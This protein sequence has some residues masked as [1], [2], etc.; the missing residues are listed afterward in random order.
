MSDE[1]WICLSPACDLVP[2]QMPSWQV[3]R[4]GRRLPFLGVRLYKQNARNV[5][6]DI[7]TNRYL[8]LRLGDAITCFSLNEPSN[9]QAAPR[10]Q[11]LFAENQGRFT[12]RNF[13]FK[14]ASIRQGSSRL[15]SKTLKAQVVGQ[16][17]YEY[18]LN[19]TQKLGVSLTRIGLDFSADAEDEA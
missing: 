3:K 11:V 16:L 19:L 7:H 5:P 9:V 14:V 6:E 1:H 12:A 4:F 2:S 17:R 8:Y 18:A 10:W 15:V 13:Q